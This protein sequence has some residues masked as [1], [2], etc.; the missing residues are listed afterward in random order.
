VHRIT[1][2]LLRAVGRMGGLGAAARRSADIVRE[3]GVGDLLRRVSNLVSQNG[4]Y[5]DWIKH[6]DDHPERDR[7]LFENKLAGLTV[8][9]RFSIIMP[10]YET[11][12]ALLDAAVASVRAQIYPHWQ[13]CVCDDGSPSA[14]VAERL[15]QIAREEPRLAWMRQELNGNISAASNAA[16]ALADGEWIIP[17]DHD[18]VLRPH[19]LLELALA[20]ERNPGVRFLYSDED[21][22]DAAGRKR[23]EPHFKPDW[24]PDLLRSFN[25]VNHISALRAEDVRSVGGW[26]VGLEGAQDHDLYL[27]ATESLTRTDIVH[28]PKVLY[29]WRA[30]PGSTADFSGAKP[31]AARAMLSAVEAQAA[32]TGRQADVTQIDASMM[33]RVQFSLPSPAPLVS[34]IIPNKDNADLLRACTGSIR[35]GTDYPAVELVIV[36][37]GSTEPSV[38]ELYE[39]L[40]DSGAVIVSHP[41][42][43]NYSA[44]NNAGIAASSGAVLVFQNNDTKAMNRGWLAELVSQA[45]RPE[46]GCVGAKLYYEDGDIQH[47]GVF[48][49]VCGVASH[50]YRG[51]PPEEPGYFGRLRVVQNFSAVTAACMAIRRSVADEVGGFDA[52]NLKVALNDVDFCLKVREAGYDNIWTPFAKLLHFES[53]TRG[54]EIG[55]EKQERFRRESAELAARWP[56]YIAADPYYSPHLTRTSEIV[57]IRTS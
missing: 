8:S 1:D 7:A 2:P 18:D 57:T 38:L 52:V 22:L 21:K 33:V 19:A 51:C 30:A 28:I 34:I 12:L 26:Q 37:N 56:G 16:L 41:G 44:M 45:S 29:H 54:Y 49:G 13:L 4:R 50:P 36:D 35:D 48:V 10:A 20:I 17:F 31:S 27:K 39:D 55:P 32:R 24:S 25:Y 40:K 11:P 6:F 5:E 47:A 3:H 43:F 23:Y 15:E 42:P 53:K 9:P 14:H 46:I